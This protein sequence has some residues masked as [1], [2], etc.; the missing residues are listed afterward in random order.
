VPVPLKFRIKMFNFTEGKTAYNMDVN[1]KL[2]HS[3]RKRKVGIQLLNAGHFHKA[4]K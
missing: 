4:R 1:E 3:D 2:F